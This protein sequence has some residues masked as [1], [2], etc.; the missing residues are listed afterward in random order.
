MLLQH[1]KHRLHWCR[2]SRLQSKSRSLDASTK[3]FVRQPPDKIS[4][5]LI[6]KIGK[7]LTSTPDRLQVG[8]GVIFFYKV[9]VFLTF[10]LLDKRYN[11]IMDH[12]IKL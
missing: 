6:D 8:D 11:L 4:G 5:W 12:Y 1:E 7:I 2:D 9:A 3:G 10:S